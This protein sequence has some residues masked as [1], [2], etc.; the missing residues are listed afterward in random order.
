MDQI[1][2]KIPS[3]FKTRKVS[4]SQAIKVLKRN[5]IQVNE[6][7][8]GIILDFLYLLAKTYCNVD[9]REFSEMETL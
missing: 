3:T 9:S 8:A 7:Q 6:D 1:K 5:G 4:V 2:N